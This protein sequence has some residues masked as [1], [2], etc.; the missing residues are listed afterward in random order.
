M[1]PAGRRFLRISRSGG[2]AGLIRVLHLPSLPSLIAFALA[3]LAIAVA[4]LLVS[5]ALAAAASLAVPGAAAR[6]GVRN[7]PGRFLRQELD[8]NRARCRRYG[9][10][11]LLFCASLVVLIPLGQ[12]D[13]STDLP[14]WAAT[15]IALLLLVVLAYGAVR[16]VRLALRRRRLQWLL[17]RDLVV[18]QHL[19]E[20][21]CRGHRVFHAVPVGNLVIDH[22]VVGSIGVFAIHVVPLSHPGA[23]GVRLQRGLLTFHPDG[24]EYRLQPATEAFARLAR[25]LTRAVGHRVKVVPTLIAPGCRV[26]G[27]DDEQYLLTNEQ[28]CVALVGWKDT[29][30]LLMDDEIVR[31][32]GWLAARCTPPGRRPWWSLP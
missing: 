18:A 28:N 6:P 31:I 24:A 10:A 25:E 17:D 32:A 4:Y 16:F 13:P 9:T 3:S 21:Q 5:T 2:D 26:L 11:T 1:L 19:E 8:D 23:E 7:L 22:V 12:L 30:A 20:V 29:E 15:V 14:A 27:R